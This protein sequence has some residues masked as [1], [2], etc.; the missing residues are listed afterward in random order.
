MNQ[1]QTTS[2]FNTFENAAIR[3][4]NG[5]YW[6]ARDLQHILEYDDW[7]NFIQVIAKARIACETNNHEVSEHFYESCKAVTIG[8]GV[9]RQIVNFLLTRYACYLIAMNA[10]STKVAIA[11]LQRYFTIESNIPFDGSKK[12]YSLCSNEE[13]FNYLSP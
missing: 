11:S 8:K 2:L 4:S 10:D 3:D 6:S 5:E 12:R 7:R 13:L 9:Q 1:L